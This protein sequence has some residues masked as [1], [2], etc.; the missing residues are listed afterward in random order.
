MSAT[1]LI[2]N[3]A[4]ARLA[5]GALPE[6]ALIT[7]SD[8]I[9][10]G[11]V[12]ASLPLMLEAGYSARNAADH[13]KLMEMFRALPFATID[14]QVER[15]AA[16]AQGELAA[17]GHHRLPPVDLITAALAERHRLT[18]IH[19]DADFDLLAERT[20]LRFGAEWIA[21]RGSV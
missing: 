14:D 17:S 3:S 16:E 6:G 4:W 19:Y 2:D 11:R 9:R 5:P 15:R 10:A 1:H 7:T 18:L 8:S 20:S 13:R 12:A 21:D